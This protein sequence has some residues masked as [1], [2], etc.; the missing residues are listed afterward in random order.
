MGK[1]YFNFE[2]WIKSFFF[3]DKIFEKYIKLLFSVNY[4]NYELVYNIDF[5]EGV[6]VG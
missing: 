4:F 3:L 6:L 1:E 5:F 2:F